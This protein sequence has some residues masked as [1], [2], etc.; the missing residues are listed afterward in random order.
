MK[1]LM[2]GIMATSVILTLT[3]CGGGSGGS[4]KEALD[5]SPIV[6]PNTPNGVLVGQYLKRDVNTGNT[7]LE[8]LT[9]SDGLRKLT[10]DGRIFDLSNKS[11]D[12]DGMI[13]IEK[14][15]KHPF[16]GGVYPQTYSVFGAL[17][18]EYPSKYQP[19]YMF[20]QGFKTTDKQMPTTGTA[21]YAGEA[22]HNLDVVTSKF[23]ADFG[24]K[25]VKGEITGSSSIEGGKVVLEAKINGSDFAGTTDKG[26][27]TNG[28]FFGDNAQEVS[29]VY[30]GADFIGVFGAGKLE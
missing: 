29:G 15:D 19:V 9:A 18:E 24:A 17:Y 8:A 20:Y 30:K 5:T 27:Q 1:K 2:I 10:I 22:I 4:T 12:I 28:A 14:D 11:L 26:V 25:T 3:A 13:R 6:K 21:S 7:S 23:N 16:V